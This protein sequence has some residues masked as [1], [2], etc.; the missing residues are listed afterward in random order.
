MKDN[1]KGF[2]FVK[3]SLLIKVLV[4]VVDAVEVGSI[5][6]C[7]ITQLQES[8]MRPTGWTLSYA[9]YGNGIIFPLFSF[10]S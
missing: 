3:V 8:E 6:L 10:S 7:K 1:G 4:K 5:S 9:I 2:C